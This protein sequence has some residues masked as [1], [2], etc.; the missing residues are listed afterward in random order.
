MSSASQTPWNP[1]GNEGLRLRRDLHPILDSTASRPR[2]LVVDDLTGKFTR[3]SQHIWIS[4][5]EGSAESATWRLAQAANW[6]TDRVP[7]ERSRRQNW[8]PL[9]IR[10]PLVAINGVAGILAHR[11]SFLFSK[12]AVGAWLTLMMVTAVVLSSQTFEL[13]RVGSMLPQ[14][15]QETNP[16]LLGLIIAVTKIVHE[17]AH[18][19]VCKRQGA[20]CGVIG[21]LLMCGVPCPY[22]DVTDSYRLT[23][24][25]KRIAIMLAGIYIEWVI[26]CLAAWVLILSNST[27]VQLHALNIMIVC[28][29]STL[30][31]NANPLMRYDGYYVLSDW[32]GSVHLRLESRSAF[33]RV[34]SGSFSAMSRRDRALA[35]YHVASSFYRVII[36]FAIAAFVLS[37]FQW[38][39][40]RW[41]GRVFAMVIFLLMARQWTS[42]LAQVF[43]GKGEWK[44]M[45][46]LKR[47]LGGSGLTGF[48]GL[49]LFAPLPSR[50]TVSGY[51]DAADAKEIHLSSR[52][53]IADVHFDYG[54][55]VTAG[56]P[57]VQ[58]EDSQAIIDQLKWRHEV[59]LASFRSRLV[60]ESSLGIDDRTGADDSLNHWRTM[61]VA[62]ISARDNLATAVE[63]SNR[64]T[65]LAP[66][67]GIL[68][69][70]EPIE[71]DQGKDNFSLHSQLG[72]RSD[73]GQL[74]CR[75]AKGFALSAVLEVD[76]IHRKSVQIGTSVRIRLSDPSGGRIIVHGQVTSISTI[77]KTENALDHEAS[78]EIVCSLPDFAK[79]QARNKN[80]IFLRKN[81]APRIYHGAKGDDR[82][83]FDSKRNQ[84]LRTEIQ[85][86]PQE[87]IAEIGCVCDGSIALP[88]QSI[89]QSAWQRF[90]RWFE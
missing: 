20:N 5:I 19:T 70:P 79:Y 9:F 50:A 54:S 80:R 49:L 87:L 84:Q 59:H 6:T 56:E 25:K 15:F 82:T 24:P 52:G 27:T 44:S 46:L 71:A 76:A 13:A 85:S 63:R 40:L 65:T 73:P 69:P 3:V 57:L 38:M 32:M 26:A 28:G 64:S 42:K 43:L 11:S 39:Q 48:V 78:F 66:C 35:I 68:V 81:I 36:T 31:F 17:L 8:N 21:V 58:V 60:R 75:I 72:K 14:F 88:Q 22:C 83:S 41:I 45:P 34:F 12:I 37:V 67:S 23:E 51:V 18:A 29:I 7:E 53:V 33:M 90:V 47:F 1:S 86:D 77:Q 16:V 55:L 61:E 2:Y 10:I 62:E 30:V 74:W 4:L 89:A